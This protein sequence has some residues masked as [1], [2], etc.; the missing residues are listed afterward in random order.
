MQRHHFAKKVHIVKDMVLEKTPESPLDCKEIQPVNPKGNQPWIFTGRTDTEAKAPILWPWE[1]L[2]H[3]KRPDAGK[4]WK[5]EE[6]GTTEDEMVGWHHRLNGHEFEQALGDGEEQ[7]SLGCCCPWGHKSQMRLSDWTTTL[8]K[9]DVEAEYIGCF[10]GR[11]EKWVKV[12]KGYKLPC[13]RW[14]HVIHL[15]MYNVMTIVNNTVLH[16]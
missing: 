2:T 7:G 13:I 14:I 3:L 15:I 11:W 16:T 5:Q 10:Q 1:E 8:S 4:D 9:E 6:K 12:I